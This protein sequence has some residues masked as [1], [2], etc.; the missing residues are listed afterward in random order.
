MPDMLEAV[1]EFRR[2]G[3]GSRVDSP[4]A[5]GSACAPRRRDDRGGHRRAT[6]RGYN[7][8]VGD[9][10]AGGAWRREARS[11]KTV[12][13]S[14]IRS[15]PRLQTFGKPLLRTYIAI[16]DVMI[17]EALAATG[18]SSKREAMAAERFGAAG[19]VGIGCRA[20]WRCDGCGDLNDQRHD[21]LRRR[22]GD[23]LPDRG[24]VH[25]AGGAAAPGRSRFPAAGAVSRPGL[26][27]RWLRD[28]AARVLTPRQSAPTAYPW[29]P[30]RSG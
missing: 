12:R 3:V 24:V 15:R 23:R 9:G 22:R 25:P 18:L 27:Q 5:C 7:A 14:R 8:R 13:Q 16:D 10:A 21:P 28:P 1:A 4:E 19:S 6:G 2:R 26:V 30:P 11:M 29:S 20:V 17:A